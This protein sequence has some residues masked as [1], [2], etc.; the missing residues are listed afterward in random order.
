MSANLEGNT[1]RCRSRPGSPWPS[2]WLQPVG[3]HPLCPHTFDQSFL[4]DPIYDQLFYLIVEKKKKVAPVRFSSI[5][6]GLGDRKVL[7][8]PT[9]HRCIWIK[10][11]A[12]KRPLV[13]TAEAGTPT[14]TSSSV[15]PPLPSK[16]EIVLFIPF[17]WFS[18][19]VWILDIL[20]VEF[21]VFPL[22]SW[23]CRP[24]Y[25]S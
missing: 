15:Q 22:K 16:Y 24:K 25:K 20:S 17:L 3:R 12:M 23:S 9:H 4:T 11:C 21:F 14:R 6:S 13:R 10:T 19:T 5:L 7:G 18:D 1:L 2:R 8:A